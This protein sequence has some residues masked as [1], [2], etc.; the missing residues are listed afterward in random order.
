MK[1]TKL[2][3][4][5]VLTFIIAHNYVSADTFIDPSKLFVN[6]ERDERL[7][8]LVQLK[9]EYAVLQT[10]V[11]GQQSNIQENLEQ[12]NKQLATN[13]IE[14]KETAPGTPQQE[15]LVKKGSILNEIYQVWFNKQ[16]AYKEIL[17]QAEQ[18]IKL[19]EDYKK[20]PNFKNLTLEPRAF[21][22]YEIVQSAIKRVFDQEDR[23][24]SLSTQKADTIIE[25][26]NLKKKLAVA[27]KNYQEKKK[28]QEEFAT[29]L[30]SL[31]TDS[32]F[33]FKQRGQLLDLE[34]KLSALQQDLAEL[35]VKSETRKISVFNTNIMLEQEKLAI[36][37]NNLARAKP[38]LRIAESEVQEARNTLENRKQKSLASKEMYYAEI[39]RLSTIRDKLRQEL[40]RLVE[41]YKI[42]VSDQEEFFNW[43]V[44]NPSLESY[45]AVAELG[46]KTTHIQLLD[47][48]IDYLRA[49]IQLED[50]KFRREEIKVI[51]LN[52][53]YNLAQ[54]KQLDTEDLL[55]EL[56]KFKE[57][58]SETNRELGSFQ[59]KKNAATNLL[60]FQSKEL[61]NLRNLMQ[62]IQQERETVF[63]RFPI[64]YNA[65]MMHLAE[66]EKTLGEQGDSINKL[67]EIYGAIIIDLNNIAKEND[68][69][70]NEL[71]AKSIWQR[72]QYA[73]SW[74]GVKNVIP[75]LKYFIS[76]VYSIGFTYFSGITWG[77]IINYFAKLTETPGRLVI[78][79]LFLILSFFGFFFL[80]TRLPILR[81]QLLLL[82]NLSKLSRMVSS[83]F[84][85]I[86]SFLIRHLWALYAWFFIWT[87]FNIEIIP[88]LFPRILFYLFSIPYLMYYAYRGINFLVQW[89]RKEDYPI[90]AQIFEKRFKRVLSIFFYMTIIVFFTRESYVLATIHKSEFANILLAAY[91]IILR[92]LIIFSIGKEE[93]LAL[94]SKKSTFWQWV[95]HFIDNY[96]YV[97]LA[98]IIFLMIM[99]DPY[100]GGYGNLVSY[101]IWGTA[102]TAILSR[103][104]YVL[105]TQ[106][107]R[108]SEIIFFSSEEEVKG[109]RF[110]YAKTWYGI[111]VI[112]LFIL[113][114]FIGLI[115]GTKIWGLS[116][117][118]GDIWKLF[119]LQIFSTGIERGE[120]VWFTPRKLLVVLS[121][122]VGGFVLAISFNRFVLQRIFDILPVDLGIQNTVLSITQYLIIAIAIYIGFQWAGLHNLLLGIGIVIGSIGYMSKEAVGDFISYFILLVQ[123]PIQIGDYIMLSEEIQ[124]VVRKI[125]PRS[126]ILRRKDSFTIIVPNSMLLTHPINNWSYA[127]NF[128]AFDDIYLTIAYGSDPLRVRK[129]INR[130]LEESNDVLK[131]PRPIIRLH[132]FGEYG[133]VFMV[134]G[135]LS[136]INILRRWDIA[137][138]LRFNIV[139][140]LQEEGIAI[141]MPT[142]II[143]RDETYNKVKP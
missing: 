42:K 6:T 139:K 113:F 88:D 128:I 26:E 110:A 12:L 84:A 93:I 76:D 46:N 54:R 134:R 125:T 64:R 117:H 28:E 60:T 114:V 87:S 86:I 47:R 55:Q 74:R 132:E 94:I 41:H 118:W 69:I 106:V 39:K 40:N 50:T 72:S 73:I 59:D 38:G 36:A 22:P 129:I 98:T 79:I 34:E 108:Y 1:F 111:F 45:S 96:Y 23:I 13:K 33:D 24:K 53:W 121:F 138:D 7:E 131:S 107:N 112:A 127:R 104:L 56:K 66:A 92:T 49:Q 19:L 123:R 116:I 89:N 17:A 120:T 140:I 67:L 61:T 15:F 10:T 75:D 136:N 8:Q 133:F 103:L 80:Q 115:I 20:D 101:V 44:E 100:V 95:T 31:P 99:S 5:F 122:I 27:S 71:E 57:L 30:S 81:D 21:Y 3:K 16:F 2:T 85:C 29:K 65:C 14:L 51:I 68:I 105:H 130:V 9:E 109:E 18:R 143:L 77:S 37:K 142:R 126:V 43:S 124:G 52:A 119:D 97:L 32:E 135:F 141:A 4:N 91:S 90:F 70:I 48:K 62:E 82:E 83:I 35:K 25:L 63:K 11:Q 78:L 102:S 58:E 137:S